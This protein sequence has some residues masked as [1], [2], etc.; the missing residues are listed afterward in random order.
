MLFWGW[1]D[2]IIFVVKGFF[3]G[4]RSF[5][6]GNVTCHILQV[7]VFQLKSSRNL[8]LDHENMYECCINN[9][10]LQLKICCYLSWVWFI[11]I[12][13]WGLVMVAFLFML[14]CW[15]LW[16]SKV[17]LYIFCWHDFFP[18]FVYA[19][20]LIR[21]CFLFQLPHQK[22]PENVG[23]CMLRSLWMPAQPWLTR[24]NQLITSQKNHLCW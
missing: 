21:P 2:L 18:G 19:N 22:V 20:V 12:D 6:L 1:G 7:L 5:H 4:I 15:V 14:K 13:L 10:H 8:Y 23:G 16:Y 11:V 9:L 3:L 24:L 17:Y